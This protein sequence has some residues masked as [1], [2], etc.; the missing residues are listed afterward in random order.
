MDREITA[1]F[2]G[3][4]DC[5]GLDEERVK[6]EIIGLIDR[7]IVQFLNGY[8]GGFDKMCARLVHGLQKDYPH[9]KNFAVIPYLTHKIDRED[10][11]DEI[12]YPDGFEKYHFKAAIPK[13][14]KYLVENS[15]AAV[16]YVTH[17]WGGAA[18]TL[19][20]AY[21]KGLRVINLGE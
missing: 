14:N 15:S 11:F 1:T 9:I 5:F 8:M 21:K 2:I 12:I 3:H 7:G 16:C 20:M 4:K 6:A 10:Y 13:R 17:D 19:E 18:K